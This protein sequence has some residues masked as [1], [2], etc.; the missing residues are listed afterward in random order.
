MT[1]RYALDERSPPEDE[2]VFCDYCSS[3]MQPDPTVF[4]ATGMHICPYCLEA[5]L[6]ANV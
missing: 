6:D 5:E 2:T 3:P 4:D 1:L